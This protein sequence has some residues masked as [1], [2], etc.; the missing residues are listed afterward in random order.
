MPHPT[1][2]HTLWDAGVDTGRVEA[3][4]QAVEQKTLNPG[5]LGSGPE[6]V[7]EFFDIERPA[8]SGVPAT[9]RGGQEQLV[10]MLGEE[11]PE[12]RPDA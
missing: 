10:S 6:P 2:D 7:I 11:P 8:A 1:L 5:P 9:R 12:N 4:P 3:M